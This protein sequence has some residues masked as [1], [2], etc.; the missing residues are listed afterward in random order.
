MPRSPQWSLSFRF[1]HQDPIRPPLLTLISNKIS[2][3]Y[4]ARENHPFLIPEK[5]AQQARHVFTPID[6]AP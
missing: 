6:T 3:K 2:H 1:P 5:L 4:F